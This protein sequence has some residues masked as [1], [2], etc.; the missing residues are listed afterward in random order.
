M[1]FNPPLTVTFFKRKLINFAESFIRSH[2]T[3]VFKFL[4]NEQSSK[5]VITKLFVCHGRV[6]Y[7]TTMTQKR[8]SNSKQTGFI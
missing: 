3:Y 5:E 4:S 6:S 1:P 2:H 8:S 7:M